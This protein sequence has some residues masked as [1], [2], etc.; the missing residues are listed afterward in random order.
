MFES[1][2][3]KTAVTETVHV[4]AELHLGARFPSKPNL[5]HDKS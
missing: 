2:C 4:R 3:S 1:A 5:R